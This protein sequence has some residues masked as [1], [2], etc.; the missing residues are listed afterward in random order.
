MEQTS[1][2]AYDKV[3]QWKSEAHERIYGII[4]RRQAATLQDI[5]Q[6]MNVPDHVISG[7][8]SELKEMGRIFVSGRSK[9]NGGNSCSVYTIHEIEGGII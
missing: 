3:K 8:I 2:D 7:R 6:E 4:Q 1:L 5:A 9:T